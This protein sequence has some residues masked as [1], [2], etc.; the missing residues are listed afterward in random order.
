M[1]DRV[2]SFMR[3][4]RQALLQAAPPSNAARLWHEAR[5][6]RADTLRRNMRLA[7]WLV[8]LIVSAAVLV[9][10]ATV[11]AETYF[12][13]L[14]WAGSMWLTASACAPGHSRQGISQ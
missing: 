11:Q 10:F 6:R 3:G 9:S 7:G 14:L 2:A 4:E 12:L 13:F 5:R 1:T 8:R